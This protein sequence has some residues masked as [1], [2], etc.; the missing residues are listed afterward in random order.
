MRF[1]TVRE[2]F[3]IFSN[4]KIKKFPTRIYKP[5][6][7]GPQSKSTK[8]LQALVLAKTIGDLAGVL[9]FFLFII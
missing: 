5:Q 3:W 2:K 8:V 4:E 6:N 9:H 7:P 1:R